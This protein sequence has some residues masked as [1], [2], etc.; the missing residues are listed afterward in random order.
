MKKKLVVLS[1]GGSL[2]IPQKIDYKFLENFKRII[3]KNYDNYKFIIVCGGGTVARKYISIL[4]KQGRSTKEQSVAGIKI[5][6]INA[7]LMISIFGKEANDQIPKSMKEIKHDLKKNNVVFCGALRYFPQETSDSAAAKLAKYF[8]TDLIN[9][10]N[11]NG[12][13]SADPNKYS[14]K[15]IPS[16]S[17]KEFE[18]IALNKKY[19]PGQHFVLDQKAAKLIRKNKI[20]T[21]IIGKDMKNFDNLLNKKKFIG[22][23]IR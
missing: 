23:E 19:H 17:W 7:S 22:T 1:L 21:Y 13:Y 10:T 2:I 14:A 18:R 3:R 9:L 15:L 20:K 16:I 4:K 12:L 11:V 5:T 6:R 8:R